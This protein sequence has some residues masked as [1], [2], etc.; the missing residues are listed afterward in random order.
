MDYKL[1]KLEKI[2]DLYAFLKTKGLDNGLLYKIFY[3][4]ANNYIAKFK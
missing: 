1:E 4:N 2:P 3:E